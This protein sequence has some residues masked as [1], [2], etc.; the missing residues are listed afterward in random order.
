LLTALET[1]HTGTALSQA[2]GITAGAVSQHTAVLRAAGFVE[3]RRDGR[4][5]ICWRTTLGEQVVAGIGDAPPPP[6]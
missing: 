5:V 3:T 6:A 4:H 1:P 2:L